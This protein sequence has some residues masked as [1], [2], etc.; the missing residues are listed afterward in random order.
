MFLHNQPLPSARGPRS[1]AT[2]RINPAK[3]MTTVFSALLE[4]CG[5]SQ[6]E[7]AEFLKVRIDT[8]KSW[9]SGRNPVKPSIIIELRALYRDIERAGEDLAVLLG[10][11]LKRKPREFIQV[12]LAHDDEDA[13]VCGFPCVGSNFAA[14]GI[15]L[16]R[17]P[18]NVEVQLVPRQRGAIPT[19]VVNWPQARDSMVLRKLLNARARCREV[20]R[21]LDKTLPDFELY[22]LAKTEE[23][24][25]SLEA[26]W[27][28]NRDFR[29]WLAIRATIAEL[30]RMASSR[31]FAQ[32]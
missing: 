29:E 14:V 17:L 24:R 1:G 32:S 21:R 9:S 2:D 12:G 13:R 15:A 18:D 11:I 27:C 26:Q 30:E 23:S 6:R 20:E 10:A 19:A 25:L 28:T 3:E 5:L 22:F 4:R 31:E 7:A 16:T 8:V